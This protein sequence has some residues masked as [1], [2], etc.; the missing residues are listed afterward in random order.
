MNNIV[1]F[2]QNDLSASD[3]GGK[4]FSLFRLFGASFNMPNGFVLC[5]D[6]FECW[7]EKIKEC[8]APHLS[9]HF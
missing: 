1:F 2:N 6:F 4:G 8:T 3:V 9:T 5:V 7:L